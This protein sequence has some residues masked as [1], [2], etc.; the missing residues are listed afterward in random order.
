M[1]HLNRTVKN[2][3][4]H[5]FSNLHARSILRIGK[6]SGILDNVSRV[7]DKETSVHGRS[8]SHTASS[9]TK[10]L[11]KLTNELVSAQVFS[12]IPGRVHNSFPKCKNT[13][14]SP[15]HSQKEQFLAWIHNHLSGMC[16]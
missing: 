1:E 14:T 11:S 15:L 4:G 12:D 10:D 8:E 5:Q 6:I 9:F 2:A 7:F 16:Q 3:L 13:L